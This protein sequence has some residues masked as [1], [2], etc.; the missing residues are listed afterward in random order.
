MDE[1]WYDR[2]EFV[3]G[4]QP[5]TYFDD[6]PQKRE[7]QKNLFLRGEIENPHLDYPKIN[8]NELDYREKELVE[9]KRD[10][11]HEEK[12]DVVRQMYRWKI[13]EKIAEVRMMRATLDGD[14]KKFD[15]YSS[16]VY[17]V[18]E[19][20]IHNYTLWQTAK[21]MCDTISSEKSTDEQKDSAQKILDLCDTETETTIPPHEKVEPIRFISSQEQYTA[22]NIQE[23]F[24]NALLSQNISGWH[25]AI[26]DHVKA[27][28]V[29]QDD[30]KIKIPQKRTVSGLKLQGLIAHEIFI[31]AQRRAAGDRTKIHLLGLGLD[32]YTKGEEGIATYQEGQIMGEEDYAG[33][34]GHFTAALAKGLDGKKRDFRAVFDILKN[35]Y[36][37]NGKDAKKSESLAWNLCVRTFRG[38]TCSTPGTCFTKDIAYREGNIG[39]H[40]LIKN[41]DPEQA[42]FLVGKYD[43]TNQRH[44]WILDQLNITEKDLDFLEK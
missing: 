35:Y 1:K 5:Y 38:T 4:F 20:N 41:D 9:L 8:P 12:N 2:L 23:A 14:D 44:I 17:G 30:K 22:E 31:H 42:R 13:N 40:T 11:L 28:S 24:E 21:K 7:D 6:D 25:V 26:D 19:Q 39:I 34:G 37:A 18:P 3:G 10:I 36:I 33:F 16:F 43:P 27:I 15:H 29:S 32:R